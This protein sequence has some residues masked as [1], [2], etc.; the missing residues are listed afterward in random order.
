[1]LVDSQGIGGSRVI[2]HWELPDEQNKAKKALLTGNVDLMM[3]NPIYLPDEGIDKFVKFALKRDPNIRFT[4]QQS[5]LMFDQVGVPD[6]EPLYSKRT[7]DKK[8]DRNTRTG[9]EI[10]KMHAPYFKA[11][12]D[13][14]RELNKEYGRDVVF[15]IPYGQAA[16]LLR[17]K[18][19]AHQAP[20]L[21]SQDSLFLDQQCHPSPL[22]QTLGA[23]CYFAVIYR[24]NPIGLPVPP[25]LS[26]LKLPSAEKLNLLL[27]QLAWQA[28]TEH[29]LSGDYR[30]GGNRAV[31][32]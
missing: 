8:L 2:Q 29:P 19:I 31:E 32:Q 16:I 23:Y 13:H 3:M 7:F 4:I 1:V 25:E 9:E 14:V 6:N 10:R 17:E 24:R 22:L 20:D 30:P 15:I 26:K 11:L 28:V 21:I 12:E 18:I 27:Q 5:W